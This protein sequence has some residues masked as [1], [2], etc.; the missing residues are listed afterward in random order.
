MTP[1][2]ATGLASLAFGLA[3]AL[4]VLTL[5]DVLRGLVA[6]VAEHGSDQS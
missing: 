6:L 5:R 1:A 2:L 3:F 4:A